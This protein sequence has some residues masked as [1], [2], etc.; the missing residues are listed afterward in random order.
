MDPQFAPLQ[1]KVPL[2]KSTY[3]QPT[4]RVTRE[5]QSRGGRNNIKSP[6]N[7]VYSYMPSQANSSTQY[8]SGINNQRPAPQSLNSSK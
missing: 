1:K 3:S 4:G 8:T 7:S 5:G 6:E 2:L